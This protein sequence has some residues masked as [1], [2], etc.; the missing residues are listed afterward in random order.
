MRLS[1]RGLPNTSEAPGSIII[2]IKKVGGAMAQWI[3][4]LATK[5]GNLS[6]VSK[7][8]KL[9]GDSGSPKVSSDLHLKPI[10]PRQ[11]IK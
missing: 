8:Q 7:I 3:K 11:H 9:K 6:W 5:P 10:Q 2:T 1:G 4:V